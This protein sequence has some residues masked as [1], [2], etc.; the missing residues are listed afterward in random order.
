MKPQIT[1]FD[2]RAR[3]EPIRL[4]LEEA[5]VEYEDRQLAAAQWP[6]EKPNFPF[7]ELPQ[8]RM[9]SVEIV[10]SYA[11]YRYLANAYGLWGKS[12]SERLRCDVVVEA[13][14]DAKDQVGSAFWR[15]EFE[16]QRVT[17]A[18]EELPDRLKPLGRFLEANPSS[19]SFWV[20]D[21]LTLA[22]FLA[23]AYLDDVDSLF[24]GSLSDTPSLAEFRDRFAKRPCI[25]AYLQSPRRPRAVQYGPSGRIFPASR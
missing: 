17:F 15:P 20:G 7:G 16:Q 11:I 6:A 1:Y 3:A 21:S 19:P 9:G 2:I 24:P 14:R 12:D 8:F 13:I 4:I 25:A 18:N 5:G 23:F 10:Q 22:D